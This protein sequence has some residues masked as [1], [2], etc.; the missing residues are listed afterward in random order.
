M[1]N[2]FVDV[3]EIKKQTVNAIMGEFDRL[4]KTADMSAN[5]WLDSAHNIFG[6]INDDGRNRWI[7]IHYELYDSNEEIIGDIYVADTNEVN[8]DELLREI[9][10][11]VDIYF[12][13]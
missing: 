3:T 12:N 5:Y 2:C 11:I 1:D 4:I 7:E 13:V 6:I 8:R 9:T 10:V